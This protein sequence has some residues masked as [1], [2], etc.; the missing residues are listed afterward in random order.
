MPADSALRLLNLHYTHLKVSKQAEGFS[1]MDPNVEDPN[2]WASCYV[3]LPS[4]SY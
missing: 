3:C 1:T 4:P 2:T